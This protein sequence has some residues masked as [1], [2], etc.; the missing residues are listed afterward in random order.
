MRDFICTRDGVVTRLDSA[1][2]R[3]EGQPGLEGVP[4]RCVAADGDRVIVGTQG[5]GALLSED[6]GRRREPIEL[7]EQ[8]V[9][10]VAI[11]AVD[12]TLY[13]GTE[14]SRLFV[15]RDGSEWTE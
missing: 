10:S 5:A 6:A 8:D 14:P 1:A 11:H 12:G 3:A 7:P 13:A 2:A 9:F 4:A 15:L